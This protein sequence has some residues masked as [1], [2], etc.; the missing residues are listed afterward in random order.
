MN[1]LAVTLSRMMLRTSGTPLRV[2]WGLAYSSVMRAAVAILRREYREASIY[3]KGSFASGEEVYGISDFDLVVVLPADDVAQGSTQLTAREYWKQLRRRFPLFGLVVQ[4]CWF[5]EEDD[6]RESLSDSCF[7]HGLALD[8]DNDSDDR[9]VFLG[10]NPLYDHMSLQ[11]HPSLYGPRNEWRNLG[12]MDRLP[13][14]LPRD[15][16]SRRLTGWLDLQYWWRYAFQACVEPTRDHVP[17]LCVKLLAEPMRLWLWVER[18]EQVATREAALRRGLT[19]LPE[20]R[21]IFELGLSLL[22]ALPNSP[23]PP[24]PEVIAALLRQT[25][26]LAAHMST[27]ADEAG[28]VDVKLTGCEQLHVTREVGERMHALQARGESV[29]LLPLADWRARAVPAL[30]DESMILAQATEVS[31]ALLAAM[32]NAD[33]GD[34]ISALR[35]NSMLVMPTLNSER[36]TLRAVQCQASDPVSIALADGQ[37]IARFPELAGWSALHCARRAIAEHRG[38][39]TAA[40]WSYPPHG[41]VGVQS[42]KSS[43]HTRTMGLLF[44]AARAALFIESID[45]GRPELAV[46]IAGVAERLI[47]RDSSCSNVVSSALEE[48]RASRSGKLDKCNDPRS[49][50]AMLE[51]VCNLPSYAG[52]SELSPAA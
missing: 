48:Y 13:R 15:P 16:Q 37:Q 27:E 14:T 39:L 30:P 4:H 2:V 43:P 31:P 21:E 34:A 6:L 1:R 25:E 36:G 38:W 9:A 10:P 23:R 26:R 11:T 28:W 8:D 33:H 44:S 24:L 50:A 45:E 51:V 47:S 40:G 41:W 18:G 5:Y 29:D 12:R 46:T 52:S 49:V 32:A 22:K 7:T 35:Y 42:A 17:L 19:E 20:E 3:L